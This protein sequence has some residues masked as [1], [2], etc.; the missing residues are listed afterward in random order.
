MEVAKCLVGKMDS[1]QMESGHKCWRWRSAG[2]YACGFRQ[3]LSACLEPR[4]G[5]V[6]EPAAGT[7]A[8]HVLVFKDGRE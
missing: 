6:P 7:A 8:L 3:R 5:T 1:A 4:T 2:V